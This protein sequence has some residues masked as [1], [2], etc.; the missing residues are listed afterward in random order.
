MKERLKSVFLFL[1]VLLSLYMTYRLWFGPRR[2]EEIGEYRLEP[3]HLEEPRPLSKIVTPR[4]IC[5]Q[6]DDILYRFGPGSAAYDYLWNGVAALLGDLSD[7]ELQDESLWPEESVPRLTP[8][9]PP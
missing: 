8:S 7:P 2:L 5:F 9:F 1:L 4:W 3:V 6:Q